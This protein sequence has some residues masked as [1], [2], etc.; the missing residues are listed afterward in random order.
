M[1][2]GNLLVIRHETVGNC[3]KA[4][5]QENHFLIIIQIFIANA[6]FEQ[7]LFWGD[8]H[9]NIYRCHRFVSFK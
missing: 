5:S 7:S 4:I 9:H 3:K 8:Y 6:A 1:R 2:L